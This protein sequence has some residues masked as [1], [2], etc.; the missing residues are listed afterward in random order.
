MRRLPPFP[1]LVVLFLA[2]CERPS[3]EEVLRRT[4]AVPRAAR[5]VSL[6]VSP[7]LS[8]TFGRAGL[9]IDAVFGFGPDELAA[10]RVR[11]E[12][13]PTWRPLPPP[14]ELSVRL[15]RGAHPPFDA[16]SGVW[17]CRMAGD[18][19]M[20]AR[21]S[22]CMARTGKLNDVMVAVLDLDKRTL[23]VHVKT[24]Y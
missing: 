13:D 20:R 11:L 12:K 15:P 3:N 8:G 21:K 23:C 16:A 7:K 19:L 9:T 4:F 17:A 24:E 1:V 2:A 22:D 6:E 18:D 14:A 10:Y 5:L